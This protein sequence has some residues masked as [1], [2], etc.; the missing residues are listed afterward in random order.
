MSAGLRPGPALPV[1]WLLCGS[2]SRWV[3]GG[4]GPP[5][6]KPSWCLNSADRRGHRLQQPAP[7]PFRAAPAAQ[8]LLSRAGRPEKAHLHTRRRPTSC[9]PAPHYHRAPCRLPALP[10]GRG[11]GRVPA[12]E[13][14]P[15]A[16]R[17]GGGG[18]H[19]RRRGGVLLARPARVPDPQAL[20]P[21]L[22]PGAGAQ[23]ARRP[24]ART[25]AFYAGRLARHR[26]S[27]AA[28]ASCMH[29]A[30]P[31]RM[32]D[33]CRA[34]RPLAPGRCAHASKRPA[35]PVPARAARACRPASRRMW[36]TA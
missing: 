4:L 25:H 12:E 22:H 13:Q 34:A 33:F 35:P 17:A 10:A 16:G 28:A 14:Q 7:A 36:Q 29:F 30:P 5:P 18:H 1:S 26:R 2:A 15:A 20:S 9:G 32:P 19:H 31:L 11:R 24:H 8:E 6:S 27:Q 3:R 23:L 21:R